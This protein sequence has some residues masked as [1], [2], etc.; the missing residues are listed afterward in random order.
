LKSLIEGRL[1][2]RR[3]NGERTNAKEGHYRKFNL[4]KYRGQSN[5]D[6]LHVVK[7]VPHSRERYG[8]ERPN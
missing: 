5:R 7:A 1:E 4:S 6:F 8:T 3:V 2:E